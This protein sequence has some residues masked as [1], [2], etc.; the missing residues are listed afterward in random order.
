MEVL[1]ILG[2]GEF[3]CLDPV[4]DFQREIQCHVSV[5]DRHLLMLADRHRSFVR[6]VVSHVTWHDEM[7][8]NDVSQGIDRAHVTHHAFHPAQHVLG[9]I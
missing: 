5:G 6:F 9:M 4:R 7:H 8:L 2:P 1:E 3:T